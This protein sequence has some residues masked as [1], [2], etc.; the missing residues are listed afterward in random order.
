MLY[1]G[2]CIIVLYYKYINVNKYIYTVH[3]YA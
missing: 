2:I 1:S 3:A